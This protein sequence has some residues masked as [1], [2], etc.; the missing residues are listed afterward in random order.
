MNK[1]I[2]EIIR[3]LENRGDY[4]IWAGFA[5]FAHLGFKYSPDIDIFT[6]SS[7]TKKQISSD[8]QTKN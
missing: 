4:L 1:E 8:F 5:S 6:N 3:Y 7:K 2:K